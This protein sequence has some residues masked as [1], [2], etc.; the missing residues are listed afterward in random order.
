MEGV[1]IGGKGFVR[2]VSVCCDCGYTRF[3]VA[4]FVLVTRL[5]GFKNSCGKQK[6]LS[7]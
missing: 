4:K 2:E 6:Q 1:Y 5:G 7:F 3:E